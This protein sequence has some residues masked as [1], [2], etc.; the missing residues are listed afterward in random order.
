MGYRARR[1]ASCA[2]WDS[3]RMLSD[4][5]V[6]KKI[7]GSYGG[8]VQDLLELEEGDV[9]KLELPLLQRRRFARLLHSV[10]NVRCRPPPAPL[11]RHDPRPPLCLRCE[12]VA[13]APA[14]C[15]TCAE[16]LMWHT[17]TSESR[18][19]HGRSHGTDTVHLIWHVSGSVCSRLT[20]VIFPFPPWL[21]NRFPG[22]I[23]HS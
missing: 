10:K 21:Q 2:R 4:V 18:Y 23:L 17:V 5:S 13:V 1:S 15:R 19:R 8:A 20:P 14:T 11:S 22:V 7:L 6:I 12:S 16:H 3:F 9:D